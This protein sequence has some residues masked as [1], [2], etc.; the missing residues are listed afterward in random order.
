MKT[1]GL[2]GLILIAV[3]AFSGITQGQE[4]G[5][6]A[7]S[8]IGEIREYKGIIKNQ[9]KCDVD[10]PSANSG[11]TLTVPAKGWIEY[12]IWQE[13]YNVAAYHEGKPFYCLKLDAKPQAYPFKCKNYDFMAEIIKPE[14]AG[15]ATGPSK[16]KPRKI[17][18]RVKKEEP[19]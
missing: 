14:P 2:L 8:P 18:R 6:P 13:H 17:K 3:V 7:T 12:T 15:A 19:C 9:T 10:I 1:I 11:A 4:V 5:L 16:L